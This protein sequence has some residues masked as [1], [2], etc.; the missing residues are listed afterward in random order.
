M[1]SP[2]ERG[3][4]LKE[5]HMSGQCACSSFHFSLITFYQPQYG[6]EERTKRGRECGSTG[7]ALVT[8]GCDS[9]DHVDY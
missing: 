5:V 1:D 8:Y 7:G 3:L 9:H 6:E 4:Q 2:L